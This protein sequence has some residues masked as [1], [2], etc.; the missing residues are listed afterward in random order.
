M[1]EGPPGE[2][3]EFRV[4]HPWVAGRELEGEKGGD[5]AAMPRTTVVESRSPT[6][7]PHRLTARTMW[8]SAVPA[9]RTT[10]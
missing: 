8:P 9:N 5:S 2:P 7:L 1:L 4:G 3:V 10:L 6:T